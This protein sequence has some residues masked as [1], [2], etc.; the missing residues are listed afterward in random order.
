VVGINPQL[1]EAALFEQ[2][3]LYEP[4]DSDHNLALL[5]KMPSV[6]E[7]QTLTTRAPHATLYQVVAGPGTLFE[8]REGLPLDSARD[9]PA[10]TVLVA[11]GGDAVPWTEPHELAFAPDGPLPSLG[12]AF[13]DG[14]YL[15]FADLEPRFCKRTLDA[16]TLRALFTR[17]GGEKVDL[18]KLP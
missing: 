16:P 2:F 7:P 11:E 17:A 18:K 5:E 14:Y 1:G 10:Q 8:G 15:L 6:F 13:P 9:G 12:G 4:W 3:R